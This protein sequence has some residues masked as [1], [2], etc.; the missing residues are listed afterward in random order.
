MELA[1]ALN[2]AKELGVGEIMLQS[3]SRDGMYAGYDLPVLS[4]VPEA[5]ALPVMIC[6]G[7]SSVKD[8]Q[9]AAQAGI[10]GIVA[11]SLFVF[12]GKLKA[13]LINY[14]EQSIS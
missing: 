2:R 5:L 12:Y 3:V 10:S 13:V 8:L 7:A 11:G 14:P 4:Q 1:E 6:G 9:D